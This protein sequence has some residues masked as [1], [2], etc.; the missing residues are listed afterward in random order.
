MDSSTWLSVCA[1]LF[2]I[3]VGILS[4]KRGSV[5]ASGLIALLCISALFIA[6][7]KMALLFILF[8]MFASSSLLSHYKKS[9]KKEFDQ[10]VAKTGPRDFI[11]AIANLGIATLLVLVHHF[12]EEDAL[13]A[14]IIGS[15]AAANADSW[16]S[17]IGGIS[18]RTPFLITTYKPVQKGISGGITLPGTL[19]GIMG[20]LFIVGAAIATMQ[21]ISPFKG[22]LPL[23]FWASLLA[24]ILG[25]LAD[26][27]L[28]AIFQALYRNENNQQLTENSQGN[29]HLI[30]GKRWMNNDMVNFITTF[31][32]AGIAGGIYYL[33]M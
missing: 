3:L 10:I 8:Y 5:S 29:V 30:K 31:I 12:A 17:E 13:I 11:Q 9:S 1:Y 14:A 4:Y 7:N 27:Y 24:G 33:L 28:G 22:N 16:A 6:L 21:P 20:S 32:G 25:F 23:L 19:G 15:V 2:S 26:S 18:K